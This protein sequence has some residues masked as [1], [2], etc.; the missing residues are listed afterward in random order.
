MAKS[1]RIYLASIKGDRQPRDPSP[2]DA[3]PCLQIGQIVSDV[4]IIRHA[5]ESGGDEFRALRPGAE[6]LTPLTK[7]ARARLG[8]SRCLAV[9]TSVADDK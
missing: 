6:F 3:D 7:V 9:S 8:A 1:T 4:R 2:I 5:I